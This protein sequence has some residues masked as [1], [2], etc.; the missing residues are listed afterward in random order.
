MFTN[1]DIN[2]MN[3]LMEENKDAKQIIS[4]LLENHH[5]TVSMIAHEIRNPLTLVSSSLQIIEKQ[6]PEVKK[7]NNWEQ[8][9]EDIQFMCSLLNDLSS[10]NN[11]STLHHSVFSIEQLIK[12]VAVSFAISLDAD[13][14]DIEFTSRVVPGMGDFTGDKIKL[15]E[16]LLNLLRNA[17]E[18][19]GKDG[20]ISLSAARQ[21]ETV[22]I[23]CQD[24]G[25]G[26]PANIIETIFDPFVTYKENGTGLGLSSSRQIIEAHGGSINVES[27]PETGT[28]FTVTLPV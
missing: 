2:K 16:V 8:T 23:L 4:Q 22:I 18:A 25:C 17:R 13:G 20:R 6:H 27:A 7:F 9:M 26:I 1:I 24:N 12:N 11:S 14:S 19:V 21:K 28:V 15:E 5:T 10:F 3:R